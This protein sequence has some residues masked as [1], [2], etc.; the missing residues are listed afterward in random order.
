MRKLIL[1]NYQSPGDIVMLTGAVRDLHRCH[2][3]EFLTDVRTSCRGLWIHH[4]FLTSLADNDPEVE[5][6][7]LRY[8]LVEESNRFPGHF[9]HGFCNYLNAA[10]GTAIRPT[11]CRGEIVLSMEERLLPSQVNRI[12]GH[13]L[14]Y[15]IIVAGGKRDYTVKWWEQKRFQ[16]VVDHFAG[17]ILFVQTG[18]AEDVHPRLTGV[19]DLVGRTSL[20]ELVHLVHHACGVL[21]PV[22]AAMHLAAAVPT[23]SER[24]PLRPCVVV[25]GGREPPQW[26]AY[27]GHQFIHTV[28]MIA[29]CGDGGCWKSRTAPLGDGSEHDHPNR[30]CERSVNGLLPRCM[31]MITP[32]EV[33]RR[34]EGY[35]EGGTARELDTNEAT[36]AQSF[37]LRLRDTYSAT[38][39][40]PFSIPPST[41]E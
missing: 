8:P 34:I 37:L 28:G 20:R 38:T 12:T 1:T 32:E 13:D 4:P 25:A 6:I 14:P 24:H 26:E 31:E 36:I 18:R 10:L 35:F 3:G 19:V 30:L 16:A 2:P 33:I 40:L 17:R 23:R 9:L 41:H 29:C 39:F 15:W 21:C 7:E 22:T 11:E 5:Q 27:P